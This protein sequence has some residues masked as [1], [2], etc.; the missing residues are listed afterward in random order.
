MSPN[1]VQTVD[2]LSR[3]AP[4]A[5]RLP[6]S[7]LRRAAVHESERLAE[8]EQRVSRY[9]IVLSRALE[10]AAASGLGEV[11]GRVIDGMME[12]AGAKR[13]FLGL[14]D[15]T[16]G[17][18]VL[19]ARS[20]THDDL[21]DPATQLSAAIVTEAL[22]LGEAIVTEDARREEALERSQSVFRLRLRSVA[23]FP[24]RWQE[25]TVG[26]VYLDDPS[27]TGTFDDAALT[28]VRAWLPL[29]AEAVTRANAARPDG[30][31]GLPT[32]SPA[33]LAQLERLERVARFDA[34]VL[35]TGETGT[36]KTMLARKIHLASPRAAAPF[37][38]VNCGAIPESLI[39]GELFGAE[40]GA[41]TGAKTSRPGRFEAA[42]GGT[43]FLDE[44]DTMPM[45]CQVKLLVA[46][47]ERVVTRLGSNSPI[48]VDV[49]VI[50]AMSSEPSASITAGRLRE[51]LYYRLAVIQARLPP[52]RERKEDLPLIVRTLLES[53]RARYGLPELRLSEPAMDQLQAWSWP[54]NVRELQNAVDR[55]A[56]FA[57]GGIIHDVPIEVSPQASGDLMAQ[58]RGA[59]RRYVAELGAHPGLGQLDLADGFR[60]LVLQEAIEAFGGK[61]EAFTALGQA[62]LIPNRNHHRVLKRELDRLAALERASRS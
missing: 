57:T 17:W 24:L 59:A 26:F 34:S 28:A 10:I 41:Y 29:A 12:V 4:E 35:L 25:R 48:P 21:P 56:L 15:S 51:D 5:L 38:H 8:L 1:L 9:Q 62:A 14:C 19:A 16:G 58:L 18:S 61:D 22:R 36:G 13:G 23:C 44:L 43:L 11:A 37:V 39:E 45:A 27:A 40:S 33:L 47:Q 32:R 42:G 54:G 7:R 2:E 30:P 53:T 55:A 50:A 31:L 49:R 52:L 46:I 60:G 6:L 20:R 3:E